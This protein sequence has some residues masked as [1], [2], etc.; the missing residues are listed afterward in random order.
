MFYYKVTH[1]YKLIDHIEKKDIGIYSSLEN[2]NKAIKE[3]ELKD[4]FI[5]TKNGF[6]VKKFFSFV[7][8]KLLDKTFWVDGFDTYV[9]VEN[10]TKKIICDESY[11][12]M[13]HFSFLVKDY[14]FKFDKV[15]LGDMKDENGKLWF[16]GPFNCY[17][18]YNENIC[19]N[20]MNLVQRQDWYI[21]ITKEFSNNQTYIR[22]GQQIDSK[23]C[24]NWE[25][26]AS[27]I[28]NDIEVNNEVFG[29]SI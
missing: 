17:S 5:D 16:Y 25:L 3:L 14:G 4:G 7:K 19:I 29:N 6:F 15:E 10:I 21:T 24:Y 20:F 27:V 11:S 23:Y 12:I 22:K 28:K 9:W 2:A 18:F 13:E 1:K 8:P 26:L